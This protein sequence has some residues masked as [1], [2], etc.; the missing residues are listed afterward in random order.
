MS[1]KV[2]MLAMAATAALLAPALAV[3]EG[4]ALHGRF[5]GIGACLKTLVAPGPTP[6]S[7]RLIASHIYGGDTLDIV[8]VDPTTGVAQAFASPVAGE[9]GAWAVAVGP[10]GGVYVGTLPTAHILRLDWAE[11]RLVD[12]GRPSETESYIW[13]LAVGSDSRLYGCTYPSAKLVRFDSATGQGEDLGRMDEVEQYAR[14]VAADDG[15]F[16]YVGIGTVGRHVVAY[17]IATGEHR[18]ILPPECAGPG[19]ATVTRA[20]D[21]RAYAFAGDRLLRLDGWT[22]TVIPNADFPGEPPL[23]L[24]DGRTL[25]YTGTSVTVRDPATGADETLETG[26]A[27]KSQDLFRIGLGP[28]GRLY[29]S[30]AMPIHFIWADP[31]G[32]EWGEIAR[33]GGGEFYSLTAHDGVLLGAAYSGDAP[34]MVYRPGQPWAP[35]T[36]AAA[37]PW[38]VHFDGENPGWRPMALVSA[39]DGKAY[40]GAVSGY[41][42]LGGPLCL[43]DPATGQVEQYSHLVADQSVVSLALLPDGRLV[44]GTSVGGGGGSRPTQTDAQA[45]LWDPATR[46]LVRAL[47]PVP[48]HGAIDALAVGPDGLVYGLAGDT[49]FVLDGE[50]ERVLSASPHGLGAVVYNALGAGPGGRLYGVSS[51]GVFTVDT[52]TQQTRML[53]EYP[54]GISGGFAIRGSRVYFIS[55]PRI[56]SYELPD[57]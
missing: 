20:V 18:D 26:Y 22:A 50:L 43:W 35:G 13:Q 11:G 46:S 48:G 54:D 51:R 5:V 45:F 27:G 6:G 9:I 40:I 15:G 1:A 34:L 30:T 33:A 7:E 41:G 24:D 42:L 3:P 44:G 56:V 14:S 47:V 32:E 8:S 31:D 16:V 55:G 12:L 21:G 49:L 39:P 2:A 29:G 23:K 25:S 36:E 28:D 38:L 10:D 57:E 19:T 52:E 37:N 4:F 17:E 53:A